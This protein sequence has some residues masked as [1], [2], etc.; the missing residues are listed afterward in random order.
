MSGIYCIR[1]IINNKRY[2][3]SSKNLITRFR[4]HK[5]Q[6]PRGK[7]HSAHLQSAYTKYGGE[8]FE[9]SV[10][11]SGIKEEEII[12]RENYWINVYKTLDREFGYNSLS[13]D[14]HIVTEET[15]LKM[16]KARKGI[17]LIDRPLTKA[18]TTE[19]MKKMSDIRYGRRSK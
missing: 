9:F 13:S 19:R 10:L 7:S 14:R 6:L 1:N 18:N 12:E 16:S 8:N 4:N 5:N 17:K 11:E 3:G 15:R 2:I